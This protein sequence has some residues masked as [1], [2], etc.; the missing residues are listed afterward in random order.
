[1]NIASL[2]GMFSPDMWDADEAPEVEEEMVEGEE[3]ELP[4]DTH[5][6]RALQNPDV[7]QA[8]GQYR[9]IK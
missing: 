8:L 9:T 2:N 6:T 1:M 4:A 7:L 3:E 5:L